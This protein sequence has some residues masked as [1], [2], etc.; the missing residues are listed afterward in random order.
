M[1][2]FDWESAF[3]V[4][5]AV[6]KM[7]Y[8]ESDRAAPLVNQ[9][10]CA[11]EA[12]L[13]PLVASAAQAARDAFAIGDILGAR[14]ILNNLAVSSTQE[15]TLRWTALWQQ[16]M[17]TNADGYVAVADSSNLLCGCS[18][19]SAVFNSAWAE[20][21]VADT[22]DHYRLPDSSCAYIDADGHCHSESVRSG[23]ADGKTS[24]N[25]PRTIPKSSVRG[26]VE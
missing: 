15:A 24:R 12:Y 9:A 13:A 4:N 26:V 19:T 25:R 20:K 22:G 7:V 16:L 5:S 11:F 1:M 10:R 18:K 17:V 8:S 6:A 14:S 21:V 3:W 23:R 2:S